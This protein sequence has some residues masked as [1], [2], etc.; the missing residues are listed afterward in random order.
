MKAEGDLPALVGSRICHDLVSPL[1]AIGNGVELLELSGMEPTPEMQLIAESVAA[2]Q[3]RL[4]FFGIA[5]GTARTGA[6]LSATDITAMLDALSRSG[7][8][9]YAWTGAEDVPRPAAKVIFLLLQCL[10]SALP[11]GGRITVSLTEAGWHIVAE[12][13]RMMIDETLWAGL[14]ANQPPPVTAAQVQFALLPAALA[15]TST[16]LAL[17]M[18]P[19]RISARFRL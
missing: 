5:Y 10:E 16:R 11:Y 1:G 14:T 2:A 6:A 7:R 15:A 17:D 9:T 13:D 3:A 18:T 12:A 19:Q 4:R 8:L